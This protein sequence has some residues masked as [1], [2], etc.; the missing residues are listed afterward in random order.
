MPLPRPRYADVAATAALVIA[1]GTGGAYA[2]GQIRTHDL[3]NNAVTSAKIKNGTVAKADLAPRVKQQLGRTGAAGPAGA[4]GLPGTKGA[5]GLP[6]ANGLDGVDGVNGTDGAN[7]LDGT[8]GTN[9][10]DG[11]NGV[12]GTKG[13]DG[14]TGPAGPAGPKGAPGVDGLDGTTGPQGDKGDKGEKGDTGAPGEQGPAGPSG[15]DPGPAGAQGPRGYS[16]WDTIPGGVTVT[17]RMYQREQIPTGGTDWYEMVNL[18]GVAREA[19]SNATVNVVK[20]TDLAPSTPASVTV[21]GDATCT[22]TYAAPTAPAGK[23]C[24][25]LGGMDGTAVSGLEGLTSSQ[26]EHRKYAF[27]LWVKGTAGQ[28]FRYWASWAYTSPTS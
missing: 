3:A 1:L 25:Y 12:D 23:V 21:D 15:G 11:T 4:N 2:A 14:A 20:P 26:A 13:L 19:L 27:I 28:N 6:G 9:G 16:A 8:N 10:L 7:G 22:G 17:G 5:D 24:L 18:P